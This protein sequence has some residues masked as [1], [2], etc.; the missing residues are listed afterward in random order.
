MEVTYE[1]K[2]LDFIIGGWYQMLKNRSA[3]KIFLF[4]F[5]LPWLM[6]LIYLINAA[7]SSNFP[8]EQFWEGLS[9][10][11]IWIF[12]YTA[13]LSVL[14]FIANT[15]AFMIMMPKEKRNGVACRHTIILDE[16]DLIEITDVNTTF[17]DWSGIKSIQSLPTCILIQ[18]KGNQFHAIPKRFFDNKKQAEEFV[19]TANYYREQ[20]EKFPERSETLIYNRGQEVKK[21]L[22]YRK[23]LDNS[24]RVQR[25][26][27]EAKT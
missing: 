10:I 4:P 5:L 19:E 21:M 23:S 11:L 16:K 3:R 6:P 18:N 8:M 12:G 13:F 17:F 24:S 1:V 2:L 22:E 14:G 7:V 27:D 20:A 26:V 9:D 15:I 25:L